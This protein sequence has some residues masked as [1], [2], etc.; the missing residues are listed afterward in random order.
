MNCSK[1][2][3]HVHHQLPEVLKLM[4]IELV[5]P[6]NHLIL[7]PLVLVRYQL[8]RYQAKMLDTGKN[9]YQ[10]VKYQKK[11]FC[12]WKGGTILSGMS[13]ILLVYIPG[14]LSVPASK[15]RRTPALPPH[16]PRDLEARHWNF[17]FLYS[18]GNALCSCY[19]WDDQ[20]K[21][22]NGKHDSKLW[23]VGCHF[24]L[25]RSVWRGGIR[26]SLSRPLA[27]ELCYHTFPGNWQRR[28]TWREGHG[29]GNLFFLLNT[30][31]SLCSHCL[32]WKSSY[33]GETISH[34]L[35]VRCLPHEGSPDGFKC[36]VL[37]ALIGLNLYLNLYLVRKAL[38]LRCS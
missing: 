4:S 3:F 27:G 31:D 25:Q 19:G 32:D 35:G 24:L 11:C 10:L 17:P 7:C 14:T 38:V 5:M 34:T 23:F 13:E 2:G 28:T 9:V 8:I 16:W 33:E 30:Q 20:Y 15:E 6:S 12:W 22:N 29:N 21:I 18:K 1:T 26:E 37:A 36:V